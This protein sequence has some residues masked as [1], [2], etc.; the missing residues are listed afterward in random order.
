SE[1][2]QVRARAGAD[3]EDRG[4]IGQTEPCN[5]STEQMPPADK[6][7]M[8]CFDL[9]LDGIRGYVHCR[10]GSLGSPTRRSTST[11]MAITVVGPSGMVPKSTFPSLAQNATKKAKTIPKTSRSIV[12]SHLSR[13]SRNWSLTKNAIGMASTAIS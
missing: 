6:P 10:L 7:P 3:I 1:H 8:G 11:K 13:P 12:C 2:A 5:L 9:R 4:I